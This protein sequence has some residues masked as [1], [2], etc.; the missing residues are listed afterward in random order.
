MEQYKK[1]VVASG[2]YTING[3]EK[4]R[5]IE[6]GRVLKAPTGFKIKL[7]AIPVEWNGW[8]E[9]V[10]IERKDAAGKPAPR[11]TQSVVEADDLPF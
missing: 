6:I 11:K 9:M 4:T 5:W 2:K 8:A 3:E 1:L 7:D 10:D